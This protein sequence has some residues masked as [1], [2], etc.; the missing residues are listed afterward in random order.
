MFFFFCAKF[1]LIIGLGFR[2]VVG[3]DYWFAASRD[4]VGQD[5]RFALSKGLSSLVLSGFK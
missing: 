1:G 4:W 5:L 3:I 2:P